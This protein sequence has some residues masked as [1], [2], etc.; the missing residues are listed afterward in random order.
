MYKIRAVE[1][2]T[3]KTGKPYKLLRVVDPQACVQAALY[4]F[5]NGDWSEEEEVIVM[6]YIDYS[7]RFQVKP[8]RPKR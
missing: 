8:I 3:T 4:D 6:P 5:Q 2:R 1:P 7:G